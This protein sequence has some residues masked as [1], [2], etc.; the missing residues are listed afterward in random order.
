MSLTSLFALELSGFSIKE[1]EDQI[2]NGEMLWLACIFI[3][4]GCCIDIGKYIF[5][6]FR[7][8]S[9][10][11]ISLSMALMVFSWV[12]SI[13]FLM[14]SESNLLENAQAQSVEYAASEQRINNITK[15]IEFQEKLLSNQ[16]ASSYHTQWEAGQENATHLSELRESLASVIESSSSAGEEVALD[17]VATTQFFIRLGEMLSVETNKVRFV[18]YGILSFLLE[19]ATLGLISLTQSLR[20]IEGNIMGA[21]L[22][23]EST[24][25]SLNSEVHQSVGRLVSD[26]LSGKIQPVL[27]K[28]QSA[29]YGIEINHTRKLLKNLY[30]AGIL[31]KDKR[32][33][34]KLAYKISGMHNIPEK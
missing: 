30:E 11:Y 6:L 33:S 13:A 29:K 32:N 34:F 25:L 1:F 8:Q 28:I 24:S 20:I 9:L 15:E 4:I 16:L 19:V 2:L 23:T 3:L 10:Y 27:R 7:Y 17:Q 26:I 18:G 21:V 12:A 14:S 22:D 5:W 31:E